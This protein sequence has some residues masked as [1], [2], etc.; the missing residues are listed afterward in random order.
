MLTAEVPG[1]DAVNERA[2]FILAD[3]APLVVASRRTAN[4]VPERVAGS[5]L[6]YD[7]CALAADRGFAV[8]LLGGQPGIAD[9][10]ARKLMVRYPGLRIAGTS[11]PEP[12]DLVEPGVDS[13]IEKIRAAQPDILLVALGQPKG[14]FWLARNLQRLGVPV[15]AQVGATLDFVAGRVRRAPLIFQ[16]T[17]MEWA[18]RIYTDPLRLGPRYWKNARFLATRVL[19]DR[20]RPRRMAATAPA[21]STMTSARASPRGPRRERGCASD[22]GSS[23]WRK[24]PRRSSGGKPSCR[25][26]SSGNSGRRVWKP[27]SS[28]TRG[29]ATNSSA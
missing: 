2:A 22:R 29:P 20:F 6:I 9:A 14:E 17:G 11:C 19:G 28:C 18:Y 24:A 10:A 25:S 16:K 4:P 13:L 21:E 26:T 27:G 7:L 3:G 12:A 8:Y 15:A 5:D 1:L 23:S